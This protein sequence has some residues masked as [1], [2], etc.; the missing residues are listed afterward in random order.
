MQSSQNALN[1]VAPLGNVIIN[2]STFEAAD[3]VISAG[4]KLNLT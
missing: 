1:L 3:I 2:S 4:A